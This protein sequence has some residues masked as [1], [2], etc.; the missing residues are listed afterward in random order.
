MLAL[1]AGLLKGIDVKKKMM[2]NTTWEVTTYYDIWGNERSG[3]DVNDVYRRSMVN[4]PAV[5]K[6]FNA[7]TPYEFQGAM[8]TDREIRK[9]LKLRRIQIDVDGDDTTYYVNHRKNGCPVGELRCISHASLSP[10][11]VKSQE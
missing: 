7:G 11:R 4:L 6:T 9:A 5:V 8:L 2:I 3:W 1:R 10:I